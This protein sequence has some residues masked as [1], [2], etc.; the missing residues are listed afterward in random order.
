MAHFYGFHERAAT[1]LE[2]ATRSPQAP[3]LFHSNLVEMYRQ[4]GQ[5]KDAEQSA[6]KAVAP[7]RN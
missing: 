1:Y 2:A 3:A 4:K 7:I 6:R 5:L